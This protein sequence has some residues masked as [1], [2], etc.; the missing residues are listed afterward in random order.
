MNRIAILTVAAATAPVLAHGEGDVGLLVQNGKIVTA[1]A[2]DETGVFEDIGERVF[3]AELDFVSNLGDE[4]GFFTT[5]GA[6]LPVGFQTFAVGSTVSYR[7]HGSL[8]AWNG[9]EFVSTSNQLRQILIPNVVEILTSTDGS[10][11]DGFEYDY[12]GGEFDEH[13]D[14]AL[15]DG[16][17]TGIFL[18]NISFGAVGP[19]GSVLS[20]SDT[21]SIVF[22][23][24]ES[25]EEHE[26]A[27]EF[28][29][30]IIPAPGVVAPLAFAGVLATRRRR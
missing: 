8:Q 23:F 28:A 13:P 6:T 5:D 3:G 20:R 12:N 30:S 9:S 10:D 15:A 24:G 7:T 25:E 18:W 17:Q 29:E 14:Y 4:P 16:S 22:N 19:D 26:A 2:N 1:V 27:L 21:I 11:V